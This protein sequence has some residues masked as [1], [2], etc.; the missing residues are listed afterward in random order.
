MTD[1]VTLR[2][3]VRI[4]YRTHWTNRPRL[5][6]L[7]VFLIDEGG[8]AITDREMGRGQGS[9]K[10]HRAV[11]RPRKSRQI[12]VAVEKLDDIGTGSTPRSG[13]DLVRLLARSSNT[14]VDGVLFFLNSF[15]V[16][17]VETVPDLFSAHSMHH[18]Y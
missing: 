4:L 5:V 18:V 7:Q 10:C 13:N 1:G 15:P 9:S 12:G 6:H 8:P 11:L 16:D 2:W 14:P 17:V 3:A